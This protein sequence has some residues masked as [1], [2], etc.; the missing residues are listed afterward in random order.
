MMPDGRP[1]NMKL[2]DC[3]T[4]SEVV[5]VRIL[6]LL[7]EGIPQPKSDQT[8][9]VTTFFELEE[10]TDAELLRIPRFGKASLAKVREYLSAT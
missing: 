1:W 8:V 10:A 5:G 2:A 6:N 9:P 7:T 3:P 4:F